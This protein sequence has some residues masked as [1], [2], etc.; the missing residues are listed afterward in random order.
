M[1]DLA[2]ATC[3][4]IRENL[5]RHLQRDVRIFASVGNHLFQR[6]IPHA[7]LFG[8]LRADQLRDRNRL[9]AQ[10]QFRQVV[11]TMAHLWLLHGMGQHR[12]E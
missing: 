2:N 6:N 1:T 7:F 9:V 12:I 11:Q 3:L 4:D 10:I 5:L 8:V